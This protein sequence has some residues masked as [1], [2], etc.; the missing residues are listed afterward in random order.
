MCIECVA[1][2]YTI[3]CVYVRPRVCTCVC[4]CLVCALCNQLH[5]MA[6]HAHSTHNTSC[7]ERTQRP[8]PIFTFGNK[9][10]FTV[11]SRASLQQL[12]LTL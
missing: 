6:L 2:V 9:I 4:M 7:Q 3:M 5:L 11:Y 8:K 10:Y 1:C 12:I